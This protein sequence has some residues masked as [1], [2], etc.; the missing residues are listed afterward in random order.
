MRA[1][2]T[3]DRHVPLLCGSCHG[4]MSRQELTCWRC[5][6][7]VRSSSRYGSS[8]RGGKTRRGP[9]SLRWR[10]SVQRRPH[11]VPPRTHRVAATGPSWA[12]EHARRQRER[13]EARSRTKDVT[14]ELE[15]AIEAGD[16]GYRRLRR[17]LDDYGTRLEAVRVRLV[18]APRVAP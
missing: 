8:S 3:P 6:A 4:P 2:V 16:A 11:V 12:E 5:G 17:K 10:V 13:A 15:D 18:P 1:P 14:R 9:H 7:R